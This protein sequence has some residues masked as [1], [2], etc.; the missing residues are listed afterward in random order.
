MS[1]PIVRKGEFL[2]GCRMPQEA[3]A[4]RRKAKEKHNL[5]DRAYA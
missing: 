3:K 5:L 1:T 2:R 4:S